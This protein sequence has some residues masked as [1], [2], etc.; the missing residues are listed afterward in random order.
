MAFTAGFA[1]LATAVL[2]D[3]THAGDREALLDR[4]ALVE[5]HEQASDRLTGAMRFVSAAGS[6][7]MFGPL[8][9]LPV[10]LLIASGHRRRASVFAS[11]VA[12]AA[13]NPLLKLLLRREADEQPLTS[14]ST[15]SS[16]SARSSPTTAATSACPHVR[17]YGAVTAVR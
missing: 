12:G 8:A 17:P 10:V 1:V 13:L 14:I 9:A 5:L 3:A 7:H 4:E 2:T 11:A 6:G 15:A 16:P